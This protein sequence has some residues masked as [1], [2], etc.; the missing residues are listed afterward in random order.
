MREGWVR[1]WE[2]QEG[3]TSPQCQPAACPVQ[4]G[5]L[6]VPPGS[7]A[8]A[9]S[10]AGSAAAKCA[11]TAAASVASTL[12]APSSADH[13]HS[14]KGAALSVANRKARS[15]LPMMLLGKV[16]T[17]ILETSSC[18]ARSSGRTSM[19]A[20]WMHAPLDSA[21]RRLQR[22]EQA[23]RREGGRGNY[24]GLAGQGLSQ[25]AWPQAKPRLRRLQV[26][27]AHQCWTPRAKAG[28]Q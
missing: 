4:L 6:H 10:S 12:T 8:A 16:A 23:N 1:G 27:L 24:L 5:M 11:T 17:A 9:P 3:P 25:A 26:R 7:E 28:D 13:H 14:R 15:W 2:K 21:S 19:S 18:S 20:V 22:Q